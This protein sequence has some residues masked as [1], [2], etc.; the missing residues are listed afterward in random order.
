MQ[1]GQLY[2]DIKMGLGTALGSIGSGIAGLFGGRKGDPSKEANKYYEQIPE[3]IKPYYDPYINAGNNALPLLQQQYLGLMNNP[4]EML[5]KMGSSFQ[6]SPGFKFALDQALSAAGRGSAAG[7]MAGSPMHEQQ[8]M[9][10]AQGLA[11]QD[12]YNWLGNV[13]GLYGQG[14]SGEQG[15]AG[16][17]AN[18]ASALASQLAQNKAQQGNLAYQGQQYKNEN[19]PW[20]NILGGAGMLTGD[21]MD[22]FGSTRGWN[23]PGELPH[24]SSI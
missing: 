3:T 9:G 5:N 8:N 22:P 20:S 7:G 10:I 17:G 1:Y 15:M 24:W 11:N 16:L 6:Q 23:N 14:L 2:K 21:V 4:G 12:Y 19:N 13:T 18:A